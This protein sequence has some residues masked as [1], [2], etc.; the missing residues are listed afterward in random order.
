MSDELDFEKFVNERNKVR[1]ELER[2][3]ELVK[4]YKRVTP[5]VAPIWDTASSS[6]QFNDISHEILEIGMD[7]YTAPY[8][9]V[10]KGIYDPGIYE[11]DTLWENIHDS[12]KIARVIDAW[13]NNKALSPLFFVKHVCKDMALVADGKHRL[14]VARYMG[15]KN[16]P[17]M[18][19]SNES[20]W[21]KNAIPSAQKI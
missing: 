13:R 18:V 1:E 19:Q 11:K 7:I 17:F 20:S 12:G 15:C 8:D 6:I 3:D 10:W 14:T 16:I 2:M 9:D 5:K 21:V 4:A